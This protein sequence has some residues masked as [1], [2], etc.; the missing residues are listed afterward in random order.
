[1]IE[2][3]DLNH[4]DKFVQ[5]APIT[6]DPSVWEI[7]LPLSLGA[8]LVL[9]KPGGERDSSYLIKLIAHEAITVIQ[10]VPS[11]LRAFARP[12]EALFFPP[13]LREAT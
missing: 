9:T 8:Q 5:K 4:S 1:M 11:L 2:A 13:T 12:A 3:F 10:F 7:Y 6:F